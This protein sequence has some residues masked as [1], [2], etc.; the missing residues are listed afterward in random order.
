[1]MTRYIVACKYIHKDLII[2]QT[3]NCQGN[4][5]RSMALLRVE[6]TVWYDDDVYVP[7]I[8]FRLHWY[9]CKHPFW[10]DIIEEKCQNK[11]RDAIRQMNDIL[12]N[13]CY[14]EDQY[15]DIIQWLSHWVSKGAYF[16]FVSHEHQQHY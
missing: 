10:W 4:L 16:I 8:P 2:K 12:K 3:T 5:L 15:K 11:L 6:R 1:M 9:K 7:L 13:K 14:D